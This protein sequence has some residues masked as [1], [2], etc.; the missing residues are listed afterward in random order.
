LIGRISNFDL[1]PAS[2]LRVSARIIQACATALILR[3]VF[4]ADGVGVFPE[5]LVLLLAFIIGFYPAAGLD[6]L[7]QR[8]PQLRTKRMD[9]ETAATLR[10]MPVEIIDGVDSAVS[11]RLAERE[12]VDV[13]NLATENPIILCAE[14]PYT[15]P[16][17]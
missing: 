6:Y 16:P 9:A 15:S 2:F 14:T 8:I 5:I 4:T 3:H 1:S 17:K 12:I 10:S 13:Q 7:L 11:F